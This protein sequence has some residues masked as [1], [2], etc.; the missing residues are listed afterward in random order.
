MRAQED[1]PSFG[2]PDDLENFEGCQRGL[3]IQEVEWVN[4]SRG[5][6]TGME[7]LDDR[8]VLTGP[9]TDELTLRGYLREWKRL[10]SADIDVPVA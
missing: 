10:M 9:V 8:G 4:T 2:E 1:F 6:G 5:I 3:S 7:S